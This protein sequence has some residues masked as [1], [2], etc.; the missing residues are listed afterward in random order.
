M[1]KLVEQMYIDKL[2]FTEAEIKCLM[3][4]LIKG[5]WYQ[6]PYVDKLRSRKIYNPSR[7]EAIKSTFE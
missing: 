6:S 3:L 1:A 4:Q 2:Y 5:V 7:S